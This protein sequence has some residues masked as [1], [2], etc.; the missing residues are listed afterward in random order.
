MNE[1]SSR[2]HLVLQVNVAAV[3]E[4]AGTYTQG[5]LNL[6]DL[7]GSERIAKS[8]VSG[9]RQAEAIAINKSLSALAGCI[10]ARGRN[11]DH[12]PFR[13]SKLTLLLKNSLERDSKVRG[14]ERERESSHTDGAHCSVVFAT[15]L[16]SPSLAPSLPR[17]RAC[18]DAH[19]RDD[20]ARGLQCRGDFLDALLRD[21]GSQSGA[22]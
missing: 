8:K 2:S 15:P 11:S 5:I 16:L 13:D 22:W 3:N 19:V 1:H 6:I 21:A 20:L 7:A 9:A 18:P 14:R 4:T 12:I 10:E 17:D